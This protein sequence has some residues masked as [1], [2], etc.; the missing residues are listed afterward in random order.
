MKKSTGETKTSSS[1]TS[2]SLPPKKL[3]KLHSYA[4]IKPASADKKGGTEAKQTITGWNEES[5]TVTFNGKKSKP[6]NYNHFEH[7]LSP[8]DSQQHA[9]DI[10]CSPLVNLWLSGH[11]CDLICYGQTGS[12]KTYTQFGPPK[13][14]QKALNELGSTPNEGIGVLSEEGI[15]S[16]D[17]GF[18]LRTGF[19]ALQAVAAINNSQPNAK[20]KAVL[21][22]SMVEMSIMSA[23]SQNAGDL[24]TKNKKE[25][26]VDKHHHLEGAQMIPLRDAHDLVHLAA[27]VETR[28][29]RGTK[30]NNSSSRSHCVTVF[31]LH[32]RDE[33]NHVRISRFQFF[34]FMGSERFR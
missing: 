28:L 29:T 27:A 19:A 30:M 18:I 16:K 23:K 5:G 3:P 21:H 17:Y 4:R 22:G 11:D 7:V 2:S 34:D 20:S 26:F 33:E 32:H 31:T 13:S 10:V 6:Q 24:L 9:Y 25:C 1:R 14:M 8:T 15:M 12:G